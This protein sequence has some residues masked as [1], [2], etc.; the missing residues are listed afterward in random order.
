MFLS[1][2]LAILN[3]GYFTIFGR[4]LRRFAS[5]FS[6]LAN[7]CLSCKLY[8]WLL[9]PLLEICVLHLNVVLFFFYLNKTFCFSLYIKHAYFTGSPPLLP[10][11]TTTTT[12]ISSAPWSQTSNHTLATTLF[13]HGSGMPLSF[14]VGSFFNGFKK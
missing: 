8:S 7:M 6:R 10:K 2:I 14:F 12:P 9:A 4:Y 1:F 11:P 5:F 13:S 3:F